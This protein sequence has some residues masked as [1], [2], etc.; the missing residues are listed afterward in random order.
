MDKIQKTLVKLGRRDLAQEYFEKVA[1]HEDLSLQDAA[2]ATMFKL[3]KLFDKEITS[4]KKDIKYRGYNSRIRP[5]N[6]G[7][8]L[9]SE[10]KMDIKE[11]SSFSDKTMRKLYVLDRI[12]LHIHPEA[13][14]QDDID[15]K[16]PAGISLEV[17]SE[18]SIGGYKKVRVK[19][20]KDIKKA[21]SD[22]YKENVNSFNKFMKELKKLIKD[23]KSKAK[24]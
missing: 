14:F 10:L 11:L 20:K 13:F 4:L 1:E 6:D 7:Y 19:N 23:E 18:K 5:Y 8:E 15:E 3:K 22:Y 12:N 24:V 21:V 2:K 9:G 17:F 16:K